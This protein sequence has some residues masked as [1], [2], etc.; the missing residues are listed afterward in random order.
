MAKA[1]GDCGDMKI[2]IDKRCKTIIV[3]HGYYKFVGPYLYKNNKELALLKKKLVEG[4]KVGIIKD[5]NK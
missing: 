2:Q 1:Q 3:S 5:L 4:L